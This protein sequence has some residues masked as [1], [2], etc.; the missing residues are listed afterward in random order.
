MVCDESILI[1]YGTGA[2]QVG[3][4]M[5]EEALAHGEEMVVGIEGGIHTILSGVIVM[6]MKDIEAVRGM[7]LVIVYA[8]EGAVFG[9]GAMSVEGPVV[10]LAPLAHKPALGAMCRAVFEAASVVA[11]TRCASA[12]TGCSA[13]GHHSRVGRC[14]SAHLEEVTMTVTSS[15]DELAVA[16]GTLV[17]V[18][19]VGQ[20]SVKCG[21]DFTSRCIVIPV[22]GADDEHVSDS[23]GYVP[24]LAFDDLPGSL[25]LKVAR[26]SVRVY[27]PH[28]VALNYSGGAVGFEV[29]FVLWRIVG[30]TYISESPVPH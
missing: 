24:V 11:V 23:C 8:S 15:T 22:T 30:V 26:Q 1:E 5:A 18:Q 14:A 9:S 17:P 6:M 21:D 12:P 4:V 2:V 3:H 29:V 7:L 13:L 19:G 20:Y 25:E 16:M 10:R 28:G 27:D